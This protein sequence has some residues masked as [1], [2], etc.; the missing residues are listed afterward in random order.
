[1]SVY[2]IL[3]VDDEPDIRKVVERSLC[4]DPE[5]TIRSCSSG[6]DALGVAADWSPHLILLDVMMPVMDG[7]ATLGRLKENALTAKI[8]VVF[9]TARASVQELDHFGELGARG[10]IAKPFDPRALR[11]SV[12]TYL[13]A[14]RP[15][16]QPDKNL[17]EE[18]SSVER[19]DFRIRMGADAAA[20][21]GLQAKLRMAANPSP[22]LSDLNVIAHKLAGSAGIFGFDRVSCSASLL[23]DSIRQAHTDLRTA[24]DV[25]DHLDALL[26]DLMEQP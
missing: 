19:E 2:R 11:E 22:I 21:K 16:A 12:R 3:I 8:A 25:E 10:A 15:A 20:L 17:L 9:L 4:R 7:P 1:M 26:H 6:E 18:V 23:H 14:A 13:L 5:L 24:P